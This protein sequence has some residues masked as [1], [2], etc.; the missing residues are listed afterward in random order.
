MLGTGYFMKIAKIKSGKKNQSVPIQKLVPEN[1]KNRQSAK[2]NSGKNFFP[3]GSLC[4]IY[5]RSEWF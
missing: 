4:P 3:D 2:I 5:R 1:T